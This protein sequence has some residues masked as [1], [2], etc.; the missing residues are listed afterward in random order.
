MRSHRQ[1]LF[2]TLCASALV[3]ASA[4]T[5]W[6]FIQNLFP[7]QEFIDDSDYLFT[8]TIEKV[9]PEKPSAVLVVK[10]HMKGNA[11]FQRIPINLTGDKQKHT[12]QLLKR[13]AADLPLVVGV[14]KQPDGKFMMLAF[15]DGTWFQVLGQTT[16]GQ[17]RWAFTHCEIYLRRTYSGSTDDLKKT[18]ADVLAGKAKAPPPNPK[19]PAGFGP[20]IKP[21]SR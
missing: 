12:P 2:T 9:D 20:A 6:A 3:F 7:L 13:I 15:T 21:A 1:N 4:A 8:A 16:D 5:G 19:E 18:I 10:D 11:P 14:K 17:T